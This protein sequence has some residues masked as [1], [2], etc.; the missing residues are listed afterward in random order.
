MR[1]EESLRVHAGARAL[2]VAHA[3]SAADA[4][5]GLPERGQ[6]RSL[7]RVE[8][9]IRSR[10]RLPS[11]R[12]PL[13]DLARDMRHGVGSPVHARRGVE[14]ERALGL[15]IGEDVLFPPLGSASLDLKAVALVAR[16][17]VERE[18]EPLPVEYRHIRLLRVGAKHLVLHLEHD[19]LGHRRRSI[20]PV[21]DWL[22]V[23][24]GLHDVG[25]S[26][27]AIEHPVHIRPQEAA[28]E[29]A[30]RR[31][32]LAPQALA[33]HREERGLDGRADLRRLARVVLL[34]RDAPG[35]LGPHIDRGLPSAHAEDR[36][37]VT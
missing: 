1:G 16:H 3:P 12:V 30:A 31:A 37:H 6:E 32:H 33:R 18:A 7:R 36:C 20:G 24:L 35:L 4:D 17:L 23:A 22:P 14:R 5:L 27:E 28:H 9:T 2:L 15:H 34:R 8:I 26:L 21:A 29:G 19:G 25:P 10:S 13:D 11:Q